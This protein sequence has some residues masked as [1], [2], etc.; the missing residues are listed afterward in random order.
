MFPKNNIFL[1]DAT[2]VFFIVIDNITKAA[3]FMQTFLVLYP[4]LSVILSLYKLSQMEPNKKIKSI[5]REENEE[6]FVN[7]D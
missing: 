3:I 5:R 7:S 2:G 4:S 1:K 6:V